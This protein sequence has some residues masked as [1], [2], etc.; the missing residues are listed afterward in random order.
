MHAVSNPA[1]FRRLVAAE[2]SPTIG[3]IPATT[4]ILPDLSSGDQWQPASEGDGLM[5]SKTSGSRRRTRGRKVPEIKQRRKR[6]TRSAKLEN[7]VIS[8]G[9]DRTAEPIQ[10]QAPAATVGANSVQRTQARSSR[11][12]PNQDLPARDLR[13]A[14]ARGA[15]KIGEKRRSAEG[16][17]GV[18]RS[19]R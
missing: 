2:S 8:D 11:R 1:F 9:H 10:A 6:G 14:I 5:A 13:R 16:A 17:S 7:T 15:I 19:G 12:K 3:S 18:R 4:R